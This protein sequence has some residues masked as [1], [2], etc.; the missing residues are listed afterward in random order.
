MQCDILSHCF[1]M[2]VWPLRNVRSYSTGCLVS[3]PRETKVTQR[4][5]HTARI[6][7][8]RF[9]GSYGKK[10]EAKTLSPFPSLLL[11]LAVASRGQASSRSSHH[12]YGSSCCLPVAFRFPQCIVQVAVTKYFLKVYC[13]MISNSF[14]SLICVIK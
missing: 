10:T 9:A 11:A 4:Y 3:K 7:S 1:Y 12:P 5:L 8:F 2:T 6:S 13:E 14:F